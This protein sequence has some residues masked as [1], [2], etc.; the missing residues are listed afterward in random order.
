MGN[1]FSKQPGSRISTNN[2]TL[3]GNAASTPSTT[4]SNQTYQVR[5]IRPVRI[6]DGAQT[7]VRNTDA[8]VANAP[9]VSPLIRD[10]RRPLSAPVRPPDI[11]HWSK[12]DF[13]KND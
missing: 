10:S 3:S 6:G 1:Y 7:A 12:S 13:G 8:Y 11:V 4:F 9:A 5:V 2:I